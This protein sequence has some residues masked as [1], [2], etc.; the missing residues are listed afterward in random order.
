MKPI[1]PILFVALILAASAASAQQSPPV[2]GSIHITPQNFRLPEGG[3]CSGEIARYRAIQDNDLAMGHVA[4]SVYN[5]IKNEIAGA[6]RECAAG[7]DAKSRSMLTASKQRH[8]Y[9]TGL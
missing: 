2:P 1:A 3:S 6:E 5:Q 8:G 4:K 7:H 9:P